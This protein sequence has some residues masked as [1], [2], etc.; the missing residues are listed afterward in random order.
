MALGEDLKA[1]V[2]KVFR[3]QWS[4]RE[5]TVV[6][7]SDDVQLGNEAVKLE[8]TVL[9]ADMTESTELVAGYKPWFAAEVYKT[10]LYCAAKIIHSEDGEI[11]AY[12]GD[13]IMAVFLGGA[14]NTQA[15][16]AALKLNYARLKIVQPALAAQY[17]KN[18]YVLQ[19]SVGIDTSNLYVARTGIRGANDLVWV[20]RA[21][22]YAAKLASS[23][24]QYSTRCTKAVH[25]MLHRSAKQTNDRDMWSPVDW[26]VKPEEAILGSNWYWPI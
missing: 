22:N 5:G 4:E 16:R 8:A 2:T 15:A 12:D 21:A 13:R 20:G 23:D 1:Q 10:Y 3:E 14:K 6:P 24:S 19:H 7:T 17:P 26:P 11:T 9:Y 18:T 25:D